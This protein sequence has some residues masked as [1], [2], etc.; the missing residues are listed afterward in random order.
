MEKEILTM[1][2]AAEL[3]GVSIKTFIKLLKEEKVPGRKIGREW[4]FSRQALIAWL[5]AGDSQAYSASEGETRAF[6]DE[7][8]THW[9]AVRRDSYGE[10]I[11]NKLLE[12][13]V[14]TPTMLLVDLGSGD[15]YIARR[16]APYVRQVLAVDI[17]G[18]MLRELKHKARGEG[19]K[20][21]KTLQSDALDIPLPDGG[22]D[23]VCANMY[24]HHIES[25][26]LA[27]KEM[28]RLLKPGGIAFLA[29]YQEHADTALM[30]EMHDIWPGFHPQTVRGWFAAEG[31]AAVQIHTLAGRT[32]DK[33]QASKELFIIV[34][35]KEGC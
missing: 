34:A 24:L 7:I 6:F 11:I 10:T 21:I 28:T 31:F 13:N 15:G 17:S 25:P 29:D 5:S 20:N 3:F 18:E 16:V 26:P 12:L 4:R 23:M 19:V 14:L 8:A 22:A 9:E 30:D 35:L 32:A 1:E 27:I 2:D 33:E